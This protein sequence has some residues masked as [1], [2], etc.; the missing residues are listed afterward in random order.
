VL[1]VLWT[2]GLAAATVFGVNLLPAF[3]PPTWAVLVLFRL[4]EQ[5]SIPALVVLGAVAAAAGRL[6]LA[7]ATRRARS[8]LPAQRVANLRALGRYLSE[9]RGRSAV[10]LLMFVLSPLP[11]AQL[12]EA[13]AVMDVP[14]LPT[15]AAFLVGRLVSYALYLSAARVAQASLGEQ[16]QRSLTSW[17]S[18]ALQVGVLV[19]VAL[20][21][22]I[23]WAS[24][25]R[26]S[27]EDGARRVK[28]RP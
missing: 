6:C 9:H 16:F 2:Y 5:L 15:T 22:R 10:G 1:H 25:L 13:A 19:A 18:I 11:S 8:W 21:A 23:D 4:H 12:F 3:G 14:L 24:R 20:L 26:H 27:P 28:R 17:P 7:L